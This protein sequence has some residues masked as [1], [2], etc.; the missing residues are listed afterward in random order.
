MKT[1]VEV[2]VEDLADRAKH[3]RSW[4]MDAMF[5]L[6]AE[7]GVMQNGLFADR[8]D[9]NHRYL[10]AEKSRVRVQAR[11]TYV[12]AAAMELGWEQDTARELVKRGVQ[13]LSRRARCPLGASGHLLS[14]KDIRLQGSHSVLYDTA[15]VLFALAH[16]HRV[17]GTSLDPAYEILTVLDKHFWDFENGGYLETIPR[18]SHRDQ[19]PH[20]HLLEAC[21]AMFQAD[22]RTIHLMRAGEIISLF[23]QYMFDEKTGALCEQFALDWMPL[24]DEAHDTIE[25]GHQFEW[26]WLLSQHAALCGEAETQSLYPLYKTGCASLCPQGHVFNRIRRDGRPVDKSRR[27][28]QQTDALKA[29]LALFELT[30]EPLYAERAVRSFDVLMEAFL[31]PQ[32][33]WV[34]HL[35]ATG[36]PL[37]DT[38]TAATGYHVVL[39]FRELMRVTGIR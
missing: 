9:L 31:T 21:H 19:N 10:P 30:G 2:T 37:V 34:D 28:W 7:Q 16:A 13:T 38:M 4:M 22:R 14:L 27:T 5:P 3:A 1:S 20:M 26:V 32:G 35:D 6:W 24:S 29:H 39:A 12:F 15:F 23:E 33:G 25:P 17:A 8:L 18:L 11:Q 36:K